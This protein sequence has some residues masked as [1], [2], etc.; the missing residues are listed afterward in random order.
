MK[1]FD[2]EYFKN[3]DF[4][5]LFTVILISI[6]GILNLYGSLSLD[7]RGFSDPFVIK[8]AVWFLISYFVMF[9]I[10][11][12][13]YNTLI[14]AAY[15]IYAV[16]FILLL[17]VLVKGRITHG[18]E[19]WFSLGVVTFQP[20]ELVK[21]T[22]ILALAKFFTASDKKSGYRVRDL[23]I[24]FL[25]MLIPAFLIAKEPDLGTALIVFFL[26]FIIVY[27]AGIKK[28][29]IIIMVS[30][31]LLFIPLIWMH[32]K[33]Y[34][35]ERLLVFLR[36]S[37]DYLGAGYNIIQSKIA[38]GAGGLIGN[39]FGNGSQSLLNFLP[40][41]HT[42]FIFSTFAQQFGFLGSLLLIGLYFV[43][44]IRGFMIVSRTKKL[45]GFL[46]GAGALSI[47][48]LHT[49]INI[50]MAIGIL[51]VVGVPLPF[52]SYGGTSL[53]VDSSAVALLLNISMRRYKFQSA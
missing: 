24:P 28:N 38:V 37:K 53:L 21:I 8:Q 33:E 5:M 6:L 17:I 43:L 51:P 48:V 47:L 30:V 20:S 40:A 10:I 34:Q 45:Q 49:V 39:G 16:I 11:S 44:I 42:D 22:L 13:D 18:A 31:I 23:I 12:I 32:L 4:I 25:L 2:H 7:H 1:L 41:K 26:G 27:L 36:P 3:F 50:C 9:V 15:Y 35:K 19:R 46:V 14:E 29:S 52:F